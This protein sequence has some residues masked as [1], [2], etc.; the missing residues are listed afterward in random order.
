MAIKPDFWIRRM[1]EQSGM[2]DPFR[3]EQVSE[4]AIS[5]GLS[6]YGYDLRVADEFKIFAPPAGETINPKAI[7]PGKAVR[8]KPGKDLQS[9]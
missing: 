3:P 7:P 4:G 9:L 1:A 8:F 2:I 5:Y 6:S